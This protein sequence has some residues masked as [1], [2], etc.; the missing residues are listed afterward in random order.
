MEKEFLRGV[1]EYHIFL[2]DDPERL[3]KR[4]KKAQVTG[5]RV[6]F[7]LNL[8]NIGVHLEPIDVRVGIGYGGYES[9]RLYKSKRFAVPTELRL[10]AEVERVY[11][12]ANGNNSVIVAYDRISGKRISVAIRHQS[13][14]L[15]KTLY[16]VRIT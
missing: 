5:R 6:L 15:E 12:T 14:W 2:D 7:R 11:S 16:K 1:R 8:Y 9:M 10:L 4:C 3:L 13:Y